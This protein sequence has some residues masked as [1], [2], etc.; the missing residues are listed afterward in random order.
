MIHVLITFSDAL[1]FLIDD[2]L[3]FRLL[4]LTLNILS[5]N[6]LIRLCVEIFLAF[7]SKEVV[8]SFIVSLTWKLSSSVVDAESR[9]RRWASINSS[10]SLRRHFSNSLMV[11][12]PLNI[13]RLRMSMPYC[14]CSFDGSIFCCR[15]LAIDLL[16][17]HDHSLKYPPPSWQ[18]SHTA[19]QSIVSDC[20][21]STHSA[22]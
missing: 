9:R 16:L 14:V 8:V 3:I 10:L 15:C 20:W 22:L 5:L 17:S 1:A 18:L 2:H 12:R 11:I 6:E 4:S 19:A 7:I 13:W 21:Y